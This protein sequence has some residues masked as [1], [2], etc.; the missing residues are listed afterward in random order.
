MT[1]TDLTIKRDSKIKE[2]L[3]IAEIL[4]TS[5]RSYEDKIY[6]LDKWQGLSDSVK[7]FIVR[8]LTGE[9]R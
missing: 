6:W 3:F 9:I 4:N 1:Q 7:G 8:R 5:F 2:A